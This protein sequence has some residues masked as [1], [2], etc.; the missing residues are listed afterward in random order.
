MTY[1]SK[2]KNV[3]Y[4]FGNENYTTSFQ[5]LSVYV[6]IIDQVKDNINFYT[7]YYVQE[8]E[9]PD[10]LSQKLYNTPT[11]HWIF[12]LLNDALREQGWPLDRHALNMFIVDSLPNTTLTTKNS[13]TGI[14]LPGQT[15]S[16]L[17][18]GATGTVVSR[19]LNLGQLIIAG[20]NLGFLSTE[21]ITSTV[22]TSVQSVVLSGAVNQY[23]SLYSYY[24]S[25]GQPVDVDPSVGESA[26]YTRQTY[27]EFFQAQNEAL[28]TIKIIK[29]QAI[30]SLLKAYFEALKS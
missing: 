24:D 20:H 5:D 22:G 23:D 8:G 12:F 2:V 7:T 10:T 27:S 9:R 26:I 15:V 29:P 4:L 19:D 17:S 6:D 3:S 14:M 21:T 25:D 1:F 28:R 16:G 30:N 11:L 18:S 13:L